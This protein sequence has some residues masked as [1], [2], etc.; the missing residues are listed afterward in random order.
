MKRCFSCCLAVAAFLLL[1]SCSHDEML[2]KLEEIKAVGNE[3]P[4][5]AFAMLDSLELEVRKESE[6]VRA[7]YDLLKIRL[8]DKAYIVHTSDYMIRQLVDYFNKNGNVADKQEAYYYAGSVYRDLDDTP[9]ALENFLNSLDCAENNNRCDSLMLRNTYSNLAYLYLREKAY[10]EALEMACK[11]TDVSKRIKNDVVH[12]FMHL[13]N[14]YQGKREL[15]KAEAAYD[16]AFVY[17]K[18]NI[19]DTFNQQTLFSLIVNYTDIGKISKAEAC[20]P[21]I[22]KEAFEH[23]SSSQCIALAQYYDSSEKP[24]SAAVYGKRALSDETNIHTMYDAAKILFNMY[25]FAGD[26]PNANYYA[27]VYMTLSDSLDFGRRQELASTVNNRY[28]YHSDKKKEQ[29]LKE[30]NERYEKTIVIVSACAIL[31]F[32]LGYILYVKRRNHQLKEVVALQVQLQRVNDE[33]NE[34]KT[35]LEKSL[36]ELENMKS[37]LLRVNKELADNDVVL[38]DK[39]KQLVEKINQNKMI[40]NLLHQTELEGVAEDVVEAIRQSS[41]GKKNMSAADWKQL[42]KAVDKL[43]PSFH[44]Q[45]VDEMDNFN[46]QQMQVYYLMRIG[47]NPT[48]IMNVTDVPRV[49]LWRWKKKCD[50]IL[51]L[52]QQDRNK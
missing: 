26:V 35:K 25:F 49:T 44:E 31:A 38:K 6:Y 46:A 32:C 19:E 34:L 50:W 52:A 51:A 43:Y 42:Y 28:K 12:G 17:I 13:G 16:S 21:L 45:L 5:T 27:A 41:V 30:D 1:L 33:G 4:T 11:E 18:R 9:R 48:Q 2:D 15:V 8:N 10:N 22:K 23:L 40:V 39:E 24:D 3:N 37:E 20:F 47:L 36:G 29:Q 7:K 14:A